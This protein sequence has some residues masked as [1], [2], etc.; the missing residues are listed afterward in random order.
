MVVLVWL[1]KSGSVKIMRGLETKRKEG[2]VE[3][4]GGG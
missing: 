3:V 4:N 2:R 1:G